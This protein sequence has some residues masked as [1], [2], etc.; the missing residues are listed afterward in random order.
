MGV[1]FSQVLQ[2]VLRRVDKTYKSFF[3]R[4]Y[5][6]PRFRSRQRHDSFTYPQLGFGL[7]GR[8]LQLSKIGNIKIKLH[9]PVAG[10]IKT[11]TL[12]RE[13]DR[14]YACFCCVVEPQP[15]PVSQNAIGIDL[16]LESLAVTSDG[17]IYENPRWFGQAQA[18]LRRAQ[19]KVARRK[20]G[21][22]RREKAVSH[23]AK[24]RRH[25]FHQRQDFHH[26]LAWDI[27]RKYGVIFVEEA[28]V[29]GLARGMLAKSFHDAGWGVFL[30]ILAYKAEC[31]GR[32]LKKV[33]AMGTS[34]RCPCGNP[35]AN[36]Y[37]R[38]A[39]LSTS[40]WPCPPCRSSNW[41]HPGTARILSCRRSARGLSSCSVPSSSVRPCAHH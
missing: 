18:Q 33:P 8:C 3:R 10:Q 6:F 25:V 13:T 24:I 4:G 16:G 39:G 12:K 30:R 34:Q 28:N 23:L 14:W 20:Q 7:A 31:A 36:H 15:L 9:R 29:K 17:E 32:W 21:S 2:D 38:T 1:V 37:V 11:V 22:H 5:G 27:V 35:V 41:S 26:K 19:R 40:W